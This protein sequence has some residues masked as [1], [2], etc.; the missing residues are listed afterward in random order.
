[1]ASIAVPE[2]IKKSS[3]FVLIQKTQ[4]N[5]NDAGGRKYTNF[6]KKVGLLEKIRH[7]NGTTYRQLIRLANDFQAKGELYNYLRDTFYLSSTYT[8]MIAQNAIQAAQILKATCKSGAMKF[9]LDAEGY[10]LTQKVV[11]LQLDCEKP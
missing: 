1:M 9:D 7:V 8:D 10:M 5:D 2:D 4:L 11:E 3:R 6:T